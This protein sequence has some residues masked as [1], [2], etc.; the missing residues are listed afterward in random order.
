M[1]C[2]VLGASPGTALQQPPEPGT[3]LFPPSASDP[4]PRPALSPAHSL[5]LSPL[6]PSHSLALPPARAISRQG[7][8]PSLLLQFVLC[9]PARAVLPRSKA[10]PVTLV[11][12]FLQAPPLLPGRNPNPLVGFQDP[13]SVSCHLPP[14]SPAILRFDSISPQVLS[15]LRLYPNSFRPHMHLSSRLGRVSFRKPSSFPQSPRLLPLGALSSPRAGPMQR[16]QP[17]VWLRVAAQE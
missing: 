11:L 1:S 9:S 12:T 14:C 6:P 15:L 10:D 13:Y 4:G 8:L 7:L 16:T 2:P 5:A 3:G 17:S